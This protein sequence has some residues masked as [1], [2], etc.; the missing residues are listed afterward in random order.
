[1]SSLSPFLYALPYPPVL[2]GVGLATDCD[3]TTDISRTRGL[4]TDEE[5]VKELSI[6]L[7]AKLDAYDKLLSKQK[8]LAG[9]QITLADLFHLSYGAMLDQAGLDIMTRKP[10]VAR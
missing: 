5:R 2:C 10:N 4:A 3:I 8:Y 9:E 6:K 1:M 7:D